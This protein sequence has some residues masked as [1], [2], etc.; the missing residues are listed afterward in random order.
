MRLF[1]PDADS[2]RRFSTRM[3]AAPF[4]SICLENSLIP[5][6]F[7]I[8]LVLLDKYY[9]GE[10]FVYID[11]LVVTTV[12]RKYITQAK[13]HENTKLQIEKLKKYRLCNI[14]NLIAVI[15]SQ[16]REVLETFAKAGKDEW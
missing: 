15:L 3:I 16:G 11:Q 1:P 12:P 7:R 13:F 6:P 14:M 9:I 10:S 4:A 5:P 8:L 2:R